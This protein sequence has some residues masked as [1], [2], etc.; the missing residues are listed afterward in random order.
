MQRKKGFCQLCIWKKTSNFRHSNLYFSGVIDHEAQMLFTRKW[1]LQRTLYQKTFVRVL[2]RGKMSDPKYITHSYFFAF[3]I[4]A[5][6]SEFYRVSHKQCKE[7]SIKAVPHCVMPFSCFC[8]IY[9]P[10]LISTLGSAK[11]KICPN[12]IIST[13][14][15]F[16][17]I[18]LIVHTYI[19]INFGILG[20]RLN[21]DNHK[22]CM[23]LNC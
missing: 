9:F 8:W 23:I 5:Y 2:L 16:L 22:W 15:F 10:L 18:G 14:Y 17:Y 11:H 20:D 21:N 4:N 1:R 19:R 13:R 7:G 3:F 12:I 6:V